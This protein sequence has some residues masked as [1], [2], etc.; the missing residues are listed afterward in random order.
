MLDA[1]FCIEGAR[2]DFEIEVTHDHIALKFAKPARFNQ[3]PTEEQLAKLRED[4]ERGVTSWRQILAEASQ[5]K[6]EALRKLL[7]GI[8]GVQFLDIF[9]KTTVDPNW[10]D[11][12]FKDDPFGQWFINII[13]NRALGNYSI[14]SGHPN[15]GS[16]LINHMQSLLLNYGGLPPKPISSEKCK[17]MLGKMVNQ[18]VKFSQDGGDKPGYL[19]YEFRTKYFAEIQRMFETEIANSTPA[20]ILSESPELMAHAA[21]EDRDIARLIVEGAKHT[22]IVDAEYNPDQNA[23]TFKTTEGTTYVFNLM[24]Q[25]LE[26]GGKLVHADLAINVSP[27]IKPV[28]KEDALTAFAE[29]KDKAKESG[30]TLPPIVK[31]RIATQLE[32][33]FAY[34][35]LYGLGGTGKTT[36]GANLNLYLEKQLQEKGVGQELPILRPRTAS[37]EGILAATRQA[38]WRLAQGKPT[39]LFIDEAH[40]ALDG[41][42]TESQA[43]ELLTLQSVVNTWAGTGQLPI[44]GIIIASE[45]KMSDIRIREIDEIAGRPKELKDV[46]E[47]LRAAG[48]PHRFPEQEM[49]LWIGEKEYDLAELSRLIG[50]EPKLVSI[51]NQI[52]PLIDLI[53]ERLVVVA[54]DEERQ[55]ISPSFIFDQLKLGYDQL[56]RG[57]PIDQVLKT[58]DREISKQVSQGVGETMR[59]MRA[60]TEQDIASLNARVSELVEL[61]QKSEARN[62]AQEG[63]L[64]RLEQEI[65]ELRKELSRLRDQIETSVETLLRR[66]VTSTILETKLAGPTDE[67]ATAKEE[68]FK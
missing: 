12:F 25:L 37:P 54:S 33:G 45:K 16:F 40:L 30:V 23:V 24:Q 61:S 59:S 35:T 19:M 27:E 9:T 6:T 60:R 2:Q 47:T 7:G 43:T 34:L 5:G 11:Y 53:G 58:L 46:I 66:P 4:F 55:S 48:R 57:A 49:V 62:T 64:A 31:A 22:G 1:E 13:A 42:I 3:V 20:Q 67:P 21:L 68:L 10:K 41:K 51:K 8:W 63:R 36:C 32:K 50:N 38:M 39:F 44:G 28:E 52:Q 65:S 14:I 15:I 56:R 17:E 26:A 29:V 18:E